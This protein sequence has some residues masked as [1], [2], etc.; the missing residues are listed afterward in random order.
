MAVNFVHGHNKSSAISLLG[1]EHPRKDVFRGAGKKLS[2]CAIVSTSIKRET[3]SAN[4]LCDL[5]AAKGIS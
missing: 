5:L 2:L 1:K 3:E 4:R